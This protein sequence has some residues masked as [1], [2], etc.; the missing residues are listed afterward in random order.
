MALADAPGRLREGVRTEI[1]NN[2][3]ATLR[4]T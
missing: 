1:L 3:P 2:G 4:V